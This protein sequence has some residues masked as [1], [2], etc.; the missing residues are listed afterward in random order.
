MTIWKG[1]QKPFGVWDSI[2]LCRVIPCS[3][4]QPAFLAPCLIASSIPQSSRQPKG[5]ST[6]PQFAKESTHHLEARRVGAFVSRD[7]FELETQFQRFF[8]GPL[9]TW[10]SASKPQSWHCFRVEV[11]KLSE[12]WWISRLLIDSLEACVEP[13]LILCPWNWVWEQ[14]FHWRSHPNPEPSSFPGK[15]L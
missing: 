2:Y 10:L 15:H 14:N 7:F 6:N 8:H 12:F 3:A 4:Q 11:N 13:L 9:V 5:A 1:I